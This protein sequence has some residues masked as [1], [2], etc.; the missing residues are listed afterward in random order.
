MC[1]L[2]LSQTLNS[3]H[4]EFLSFLLR[5]RRAHTERVPGGRRVEVRWSR[6]RRRASRRGL[7][8]RLYE[9]D[10]SL[11]ASLSFSLRRP[12]ARH[13]TSGKRHHFLVFASKSGVVRAFRWRRPAGHSDCRVEGS[14]YPRFRAAILASRAEHSPNR[15]S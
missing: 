12:H 11:A 10:S 5:S 7:Y 3:T 14:L 4:T 1:S 6:T 13:F 15:W 9:R 8:S 2:P